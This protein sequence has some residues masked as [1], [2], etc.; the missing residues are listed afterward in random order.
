M[1]RWLLGWVAASGLMLAL[2]A[3]SA[4]AQEGEDAAESRATAFRAVQGAQQEDVPGGGL[5]IGAYAV[6]LAALVAYVARL[7]MLQKRND[8][9][10]ARLGAAIDKAE[11]RD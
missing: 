5:M 11:K 3:V 4:E 7:G 9:E 10:L 2:G 1:K 6:A 8:G